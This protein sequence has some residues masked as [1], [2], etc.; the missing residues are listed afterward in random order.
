MTM[1]GDCPVLLAETQ[2]CVS[3]GLGVP[4]QHTLYY[5]GHLL[6]GVAPDASLTIVE[7]QM[8]IIFHFHQLALELA[9]SV[10]VGMKALA[11]IESQVIEGGHVS[12]SAVPEHLAI[13]LK[14]LHHL[15]GQLLP[16]YFPAQEL[17]EGNR[18]GR[19]TA[20]NGLVDIDTHTKDTILELSL[21]HGSLY[22]R[23]AQLAVAYV[24]IIRPLQRHSIHIA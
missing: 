7:N 2:E 21:P 23:A 15:L 6:E 4:H 24:D 9:V 14:G 3:T 13:P 18:I 10:S 8:A 16:V 5:I 1:P 11:P 19:V 17:E 12:V 22:Q 20:E